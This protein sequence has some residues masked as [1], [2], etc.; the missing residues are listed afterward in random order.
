MR[1]ELP[2]RRHC[3]RMAKN[4]MIVIDGSAG[5]GGGQIL[6][7][8]LALSLVTG[9]PFRIENIRAGRIKPG[10]LRQHLTA[11]TAATRIGNAKVE[12]AA[13]GSKTVSFAPRGV[14]PGD[15][16]FAVGTAGSA[17]LVLQTVLPALM[18]ASGPSTLVLEGGTHNPAAPPFDFIAKAFL[19]I[20]NRMGPC[21]E[22]D[23]ERHGFYPAGGGRFRVSVKPVAQLSPI[24]LLACGESRARKVRLLLSALPRSIAE[25]EQAVIQTKTGWSDDVF[26]IL[27]IEDSSGPGNVILIECETEHVTEVFVAFGEKQVAGGTVATN[28]VNAARAWMASAVPVG[29]FLA[30]QLLIP[31]ALAG[32]GAFMTMPLSR[33]S[34]TN[35]EVIQQFLDLKITVENLPE[36]ASLVKVG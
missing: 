13:L 10:L 31:F 14:T 27:E 9:K 30:D 2:F 25:R 16:R 5:E 32:S 15:Y 4:E 22:A 26:E 17:T 29:R 36:R 24:E 18:T 19:P 21:I 28:A 7:S 20:L 33:H 23:L 35:I 12:G 3:E 6:R 1:G 8:S 34:Q 11:L